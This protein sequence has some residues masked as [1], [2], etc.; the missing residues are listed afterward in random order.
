PDEIEDFLR[1]FSA[2]GL[3]GCNVTLPHKEA[4]CRLAGRAS[5][6]AQRIGAAN[7]LWLDDG[8]LCADN[9]DVHGFTANLDDAAPG[10]DAARTALVIGAGGAARAVVAGLV[11]RRFQRVAI[12]NRSPRRAAELAGLFADA[13]ATRL[14]AA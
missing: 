3:A 9:T 13:R 2:H 10:W 8:V 11:E 6:L 5:A 1:R 7:T 14:E 12:V 4:A